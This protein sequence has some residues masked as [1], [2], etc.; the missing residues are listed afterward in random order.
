[1]IK[2]CGDR[3]DWGRACAKRL[4]DLEHAF[5]TQTSSEI[6]NQQKAIYEKYYP[7]LILEMQTTAGCLGGFGDQ[8]LYEELASP[9]DAWRRRLKRG[10]QNGCTIFAFCRDNKVFVGRN[11]DWLP[12]MRGMFQVYD[13]Y[14]DG[15]LRYI[16]FSDEAVWKEHTGPEVWKF[17]S[18][19]AINERGLFIGLTYAYID[20]WNYGLSPTHMIRYIAEHCATTEQALD[21]FRRIPVAIPKNFFLAD[22]KGDLAVVEHA[23]DS[24]RI[25]QPNDDGILIHTNHCIA[26]DLQ[27]ED[28]I[29]EYDA[30]SSSFLRY[31]EAAYLIRNSLNNTR[32]PILEAI[33][34]ILRKS[35]YVYNE[36]TLWS[37]ALELTKKKILLEWD[38]S[39]GR[40]ER[41]WLSF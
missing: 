9:L 34:Q 37:L 15:C 39:S 13:M 24:F 40:Q 18:V 3:R 12:A 23:A 2:G 22:A 38:D 32:E 10:V 6:F 33:M 41:N 16:A 8:F 5:C 19:D 36:R 27:K 14:L 4:R 1:M 28:R 35:S 30:A 31:E 25:I 21:T 17:S 7:E 29:L 20:R 26:S 11:Y